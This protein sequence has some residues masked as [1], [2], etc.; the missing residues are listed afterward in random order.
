MNL[1]GQASGFEKIT[2][3]PVNDG[4][5]DASDNE[6]TTTQ[7]NNELYLRATGAPI[8]TATSVDAYNTKL[9]VKFL[10]PI[11]NTNSGSGLPGV[12]DFSLALSGG[13]ATLTS[14]TPTSISG[15]NGPELEF[16]FSTSGVADGN[17]TITITPVQ[18]ALWDIDGTVVSNSQ[19]NNTVSL[20]ASFM[21]PIT[22]F[23]HNSGNATHNSMIHISGAVSYTHLTLPTIYSV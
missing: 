11:F 14:A 9:T 20:N 2:V 4:I 15:R 10:K 8:I 17:E 7:L 21:N 18:N 16:T 23:E 12:S 1:S 6:A 22:N 19:S 13:T 5:F 3:T